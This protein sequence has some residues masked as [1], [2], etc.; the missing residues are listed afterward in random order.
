ML[1]VIT[2][3]RW[4]ILRCLRSIS[5]NRNELEYA[6]KVEPLMQTT[7]SADTHGSQRIHLA[8][9]DD[10]VK[11]H[12]VSQWRWHFLCLLVK[13]LN[14]SG[15][16]CSQILFVRKNCN[17]FSLLMLCNLFEYLNQIPYRSIVQDFLI[18][19]R[20]KIHDYVFVSL[21]LLLLL[22]LLLSL[23]LYIITFEWGF[24][25]C[26]ESGPSSTDLPCCTAMFLQ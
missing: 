12:L 17:N 10:P 8:D 22:L 13:C 7:F 24:Y 6:R 20:Y 9:F 4:H 25:I 21:F 5:K 3:S 16:D 18:E 19:V 2:F 11:F 14:N 15:V 23:L 26:R 1:L